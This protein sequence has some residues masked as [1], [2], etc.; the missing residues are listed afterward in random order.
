MKIAK[1]T[2][3]ALSVI[4]VMPLIGCTS[5]LKASVVELE[6]K[7]ARPDWIEPYLVY[8]ISRVQAQ[9][10]FKNKYCIIGEAS[11]VNQESVIAWADDSVQQRIG[12]MLRTTIDNKYQAAITATAVTEAES[13]ALYWPL[14]QVIDLV[15]NLRYSGAQREEDWWNLIR[16]YDPDN[17]EVY[18]DEYT[19]YVLYTIPKAE[20]NMQVAVALSTAVSKD[21]VLY[22][23]TIEVA[24]QILLNGLEYDH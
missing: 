13:S 23:I 24:R 5:K 15:V 3:M 12:T 7:G 19:V 22:D 9:S 21:S 2:L 18:T 16:H 20:L 8:G 10:E 1:Q 17:R 4:T 11:G 6:N 14:A